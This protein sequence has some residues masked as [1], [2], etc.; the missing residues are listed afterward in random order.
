MCVYSLTHTEEDANPSSD[1][2]F[3]FGIGLKFFGKWHTWSRGRAA[4]RRRAARYVLV[5]RYLS[6]FRILFTA[7]NNKCLVLLKSLSLSYLAVAKHT[8]SGTYKHT[9][10]E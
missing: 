5:R 9:Q 4:P 10:T 2:A 3:A 8:L 7:T 1:I 6:V